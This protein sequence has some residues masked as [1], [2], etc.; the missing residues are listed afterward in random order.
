MISIVVADD[1]TI[2]RDGICNLISLQSNFA[3]IGA[4]A[5]GEEALELIQQESPDIA[6]LD[7]QMPKMNGIE[8]LKKVK[9]NAVHTKCILLTT[10]ND[11]AYLLDAMS[12]NVDGYLLKDVD[13]QR[14]V[15]AINRIHAGEQVIDVPLPSRVTDQANKNAAYT[16]STISSLSARELLILQLIATG[17]DNKEISKSLDIATGTVKNHVSNIL[18]KFGVRDRTQAVLCAIEKGVL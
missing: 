4:A 13:F 10:F 16:D 8:V 1:Q 11:A 2:V 15:S 7:I 18:S 14:L 6:L 12:A 9:E 5:D 17:M 3:V